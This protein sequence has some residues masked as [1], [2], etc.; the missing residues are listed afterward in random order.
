[1]GGEQVR[2]SRLWP[3]E[4]E[5]SEHLEEMR[6]LYNEALPDLATHPL[7][8]TS[9]SGQVDWWLSR[10]PK[11]RAWIVTD[12]NSAKTV[13]FILLT[14]RT[15]FE[16]PLFVIAPEF[17][18]RGLARWFV[19][20]YIEYAKGALGGEQLVSNKGICKVNAEMGWE[21]LAE[22]DGVQY[23]YHVGRTRDKVLAFHQLRGEL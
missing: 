14:E 2:T 10:Y 15:G 5:T 1:M 17:R 19:T 20:Q 8:P 9:Y 11:K 22:K 12:V 18:G 21:I 13:G 7:E 6:R 23:L 3:R 4:V 16:T